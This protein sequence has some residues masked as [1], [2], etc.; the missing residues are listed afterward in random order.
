LTSS[1]VT[2]EADDGE[3]VTVV[4]QLGNIVGSSEGPV[5]FSHAYN[6]HINHWLYL[7]QLGAP[8]PTITLLHPNGS[9]HE[10]AVVVFADDSLTRRVLE[11]DETLEMAAENLK[12]DDEISD[13]ALGAGG[14]KQNRSKADVVP[15]LKKK[16]HDELSR[17]LPTQTLQLQSLV[18]ELHH[19]QGI[20]EHLRISVGLSTGK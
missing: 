20:L 16:L 5:L 17:K 7:R 14:W 13:I 2:F 6:K 4:P 1:A 3:E 11:P 18:K 9:V 19:G 8:C 12:K 15:A 10:G